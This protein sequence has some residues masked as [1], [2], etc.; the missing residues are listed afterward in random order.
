MDVSG[1]ASLSV[2]TTQA[3]AGQKQQVMMLKKGLDQ[4]EATGQAAMKLLEAAA[5]TG[6][7]GG[8]I[9]VRA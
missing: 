4:M 9:N 1:I 5:V 3:Q 7:G 6:P 8:R 2:A